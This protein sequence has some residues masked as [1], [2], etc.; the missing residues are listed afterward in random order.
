LTLN[1]DRGSDG[2]IDQSELLSNEGHVIYLPML[3][4]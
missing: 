3:R 2:V 1:T 4:G